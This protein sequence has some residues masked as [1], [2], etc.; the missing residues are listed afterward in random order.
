MFL[1]RLYLRN[2]RNYEE[3]TVSFDPKINLIQGENAQGKTNLLEAIYLLSTGKS[4][5]ANR[6][7]ELVRH[8][9]DFFYLEA[10]F[11]RDQLRES[12]KIHFDGQSRKMHYNN[13]AYPSFN[14]L[15][16]LMPS[17]LF[18]PEDVS[19]ISGSPME[20]RR[21]LNLHIAQ[22]DP[23]YVHHLIRF[24]QAM[25]QRNLLLKQ[26]N[27]T[28]I[29]VWEA[30]MTLS[31]AYLV[32]KRSEAIQDLQIP[33]NRQMQ[34]L[35]KER[36]T[37]EIAYQPSLF[38]PKQRKREMAIGA[39]LT[40]PHRDDLTI[41]ISGKEAKLYS[42]E[43]QKRSAIAALRL[44]E[45]ERLEKLS[46]VSPILSID[47]FG[48]H[49]D[50]NRHSLFQQKLATLGQVFLTSP[51]PLPLRTHTLKIERGLITDCIQCESTQDL[52]KMTEVSLT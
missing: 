51:F 9:A 23:L 22:I 31:A 19:F 45:W 36:D 40:G 35:T 11:V 44:A 41:Q 49:L 3:I 25:R 14:N 1:E 12:L 24:S 13:T 43:G 29:E 27:E 16:G 5:R 52:R 48:V 30:M 15:L 7:S 8:G 4:F 34:L 2:F 17:V 32:Q 21:F 33:L 39:T 28:A 6:L 42:S 38:N 37:L 47:D 50:A 10:Q 26:E 46:Q 20:R 18:A